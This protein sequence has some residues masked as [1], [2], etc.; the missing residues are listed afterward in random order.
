MS[1]WLLWT[2]WIKNFPESSKNTKNNGKKSN[3]FNYYTISEKKFLCNP[4]HAKEIIKAKSL[5]LPGEMLFKN[6]LLFQDLPFS[7]LANQIYLMK[8]M[9]KW[10]FGLLFSRP[11]KLSLKIKIQENEYIFFLNLFNKGGGGGC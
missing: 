9:R 8:F 3:Y 1:L 5:L 11:F 2:W 7:I 6:Y 4:L 10:Y